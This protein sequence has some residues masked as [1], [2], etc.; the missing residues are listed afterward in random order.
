MINKNLK[1][2]L[3]VIAFSEGTKDVG[4]DG[5]N[6]IVGGALFHDYEEHPN[7]RI[8]IKRL[9]I[10]STAAGRFQ[11]LFH[12]WDVYRKQ[13]DLENKQK[14]QEGAFGKQAQIAIALQ[15]IGERHALADIDAGRFDAAVGKC[16]RIWASLPGNVY[17]QREKPIGELKAAYINYG[18]KAIIS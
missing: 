18:G 17:G 4:D 6:V 15:M 13:L 16:S 11:I 10:Y 1:A 5:Y 12:D 7:Q 14:Y 9:N 2:F 8:F 3:D